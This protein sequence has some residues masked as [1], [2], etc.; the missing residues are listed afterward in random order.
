M[1]A[2]PDPAGGVRAGLA[3]LAQ[4]EVKEWHRVLEALR[5]IN[6]RPSPAALFLE[7]DRGFDHAIGPELRQAQAPIK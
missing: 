3:K 5:Q 7:R 2:E 6:A 1:L 4:S